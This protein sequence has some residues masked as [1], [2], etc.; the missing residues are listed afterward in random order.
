MAQGWSASRAIGWEDVAEFSDA[1]GWA[2]NPAY[3]GTIRFGDVDGDKDADVCGRTP[4]GVTCARSLGNGFDHARPWLADMS[5]AQGW[6]APDQAMT[7]QLADVNGDGKADVCARGRDGIVCAIS[8]GSAFGR[9]ERWSKGTD[10]ANAD[11]WAK[12]VGYYGTIRFGDLNGDGRADVC[13]R[14]PD[15]VVCAFSTGHGFTAATYWAR[16]GMTDADGWLAPGRAASFH[17]ADINGD[18]RA[19]LCAMA[20]GGVLCG[21]AP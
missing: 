12:N 21:L 16:A 18:G 8:T 14:A 2:A 7:I 6:L 5:D 13:G 10:F 17:L 9:L 3:E 15:G 1:E 11:G 20:E 19:D 4:A